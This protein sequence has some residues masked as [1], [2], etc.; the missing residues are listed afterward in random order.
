M[1]V[2]AI[3]LS[4]FSCDFQERQKRKDDLA[5][6]IP[7]EPDVDDPTAIRILLKAPNGKRLERR[8]SSHQSSKVMTKGL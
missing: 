2:M 8:F 4:S 5:R 1:N 3:E 6:E 7:P